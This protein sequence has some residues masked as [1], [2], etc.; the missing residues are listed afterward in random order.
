[1]NIYYYHYCYFLL[2]CLSKLVL[3]QPMNSLFF[4]PSDS[5]PIPSGRKEASERPCGAELLSGLNHN[6]QTTA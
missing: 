4:F 1:M 5:L 2:F 6:I 3:S